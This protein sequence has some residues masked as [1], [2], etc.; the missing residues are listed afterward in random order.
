MSDITFWLYRDS[1]LDSWEVVGRYAVVIGSTDGEVIP[2]P[3]AH[4]YSQAIAERERMNGKGNGE[5]CVL[6]V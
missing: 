5:Q 4:W 2:L 1:P 3:D 6:Q